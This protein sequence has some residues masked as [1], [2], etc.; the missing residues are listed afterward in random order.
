[1]VSGRIV[2]LQCFQC[3]VIVAW[4]FIDIIVFFPCE[5][6][7]WFGTRL[8]LQWLFFVMFVLFFLLFL[9]RV[10][11]WLLGLWLIPIRITYFH[12]SHW[13][14]FTRAHLKTRIH[15][16]ILLGFGCN[17]KTYLLLGF[18]LFETKKKH[19]HTDN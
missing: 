16:P 12:F 17:E 7:F 4:L 2:S 14:A 18:F 1:M 13:L 6:R 15:Q 11:F 5:L 19:I 10:F 3:N 9:F 8:W